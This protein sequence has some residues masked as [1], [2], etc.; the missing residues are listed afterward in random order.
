[1]EPNIILIENDSFG[2][3]NYDV[4]R[5][6]LYMVDMNMMRALGQAI[7]STRQCIVMPISDAPMCAKVGEQHWIFLN[8]KDNLLCQ[9]VYQF[10]HEYCHHLINGSLSGEWSDMLWFEETIC[11]LSSI[12]NLGIM[13]SFC[14]KIGL[15]GYAPSVRNY[16]NNLLIKN[17]GTY[18]ISAEGGWYRQYET[19]LRDVKYQR[20]LY[21]AIAVMIYPLFVEN[22]NLWKL[23]LNIGDIRSWVTLESLFSHLAACA[24]DSYRESLSRLQRMFT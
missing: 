4:V 5:A 11:E 17:K 18:R 8:T 20:K 6:L 23:I 13:V 2:N 1:M 24:D 22:P 10:A 14:E 21:N 19:S 7:F 15:H 9:W 12:Y 16:Y 3:T